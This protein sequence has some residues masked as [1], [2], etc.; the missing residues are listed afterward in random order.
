MFSKFSRFITVTEQVKQTSCEIP[1]SFGGKKKNFLMKMLRLS[2]ILKCLK[3]SH[4]T[5]LSS[6]R[7]TAN[8]TEPNEDRVLFRFQTFEENIKIIKLKRS[9]SYL[10]LFLKFWQVCRKSEKYVN[11]KEWNF[12]WSQINVLPQTNANSK[13]HVFSWIWWKSYYLKPF[14]HEW[15]DSVCNP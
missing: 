14:K 12:C 9:H 13:V 7:S 5:F 2:K 8:C 11:S 1:I 3:T 15:F 4:V 10:Q 6:T